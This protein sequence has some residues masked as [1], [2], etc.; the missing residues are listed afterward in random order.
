MTLRSNYKSP[1]RAEQRLPGELT[2]HKRGITMIIIN[3]LDGML[4]IIKPVVPVLNCD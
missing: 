4:N 1:K 2:S 3:K